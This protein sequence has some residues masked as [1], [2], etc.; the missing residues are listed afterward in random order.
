[1]HA[2][3]QKICQTPLVEITTLPFPFPPAPKAW[4]VAQEACRVLGKMD[5]WKDSTDAY[6]S[7]AHTRINTDL[8]KPKQ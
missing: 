3:L 6:C 8:F 1:M 5:A 2:E 4:E 7:L